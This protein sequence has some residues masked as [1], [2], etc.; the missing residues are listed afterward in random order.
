MAKTEQ[1]IFIK[2]FVIALILY[3]SLM[4]TYGLFENILSQSVLDFNNRIADKLN[5]G[6]GFNKKHIYFELQDGKII[7][8]IHPKVNFAG[9]NLESSY[10]SKDIRLHFFM[11]FVIVLAVSLLFPS[12]KAIIFTLICIVLTCLF[13]EFKLWLYVYN[14]SNHYLAILENGTR[15][16]KLKDGVMNWFINLINNIINIKGAITIRYLIALVNCTLV[17]YLLNRK[18]E[19]NFFKNL[20]N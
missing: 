4:S 20:I 11:P 14:Q 7:G 3:F 15:E 16:I 17:Y 12:Q 2:R 8:Y 19:R 10:V 5:S 6:D 1:K 18:N 9:S 13:V